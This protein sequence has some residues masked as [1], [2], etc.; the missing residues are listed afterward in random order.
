MITI[1]APPSPDDHEEEKA[2][3]KGYNGWGCG[4]SHGLMLFLIFLFL[5]PLSFYVSVCAF[6]CGLF[7]MSL[8]SY[9][10]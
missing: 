2:Q 5:F 10:V 3:E 1:A 9:P 7:C 6:L 4:V 8:L